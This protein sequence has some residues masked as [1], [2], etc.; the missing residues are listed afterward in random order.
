MIAFFPYGTNSQKVFNNSYT[1]RHYLFVS[2]QTRFEF[3]V[4]NF[5]TY[6]ET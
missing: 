5:Y 1:F 2:C 4:D 3:V 6:L